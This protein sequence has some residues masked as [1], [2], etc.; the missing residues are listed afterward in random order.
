MSRKDA[1]ENVWQKVNENGQNPASATPTD[2]VENEF[3]QMIDLADQPESVSDINPVETEEEPAAVVADSAEEKDSS[4]SAESASEGDFYKPTLQRALARHKTAWAAWKAQILKFPLFFANL[5]YEIGYYAEYGLVCSARAL[6]KAAGFVGTKLKL[7]LKFTVRMLV[8]ALKV[9]L[10]LFWIPASH[11]ISAFHNVHDIWYSRDPEQPRETWKETGCYLWGGLRRHVHLIFDLLG[12]VLPVAAG[13]LFVFTVRTVMDYQYVLQ[14]SYDDQVLGYVASEEVF[15][16]AQ[17]DVKSRIVYTE[18]DAEQQWDLKPSYTLAVN[19]GIKLLNEDEVADAI[20]ASSGEEIIEATGLYM[21]GV[22]YGAVTEADRLRAELED[23]KAPYVTGEPDETVSFVNEPELVDG[24]YLRSSVV[25]YDNISELIH[26]QVAGEVRYTV[27]KGDSP[28]A[29]AHSYGL[30]TA[31][32][33]AMN[34]AMEDGNRLFVGDSLLV[35]QAV[36]FLQVQVTYRR[37]EQEEVAYQSVR[38]TTADLSFG[39][40]KVKTKGVNGVNECEYDYVYVDGILTSKTLV[41]TTV[42]SEP[43]NEEVL[44]G[45]A[46][47]PGV[48]MVPSSG[49]FMWPVPGYKYVSRGFTGLYAHNGM[50]ICGAYGTPIYAA[51]SGVVT[52]AKY[53]GS[54]YGVYVAIDHGNG[55]STLYGHCS[56]LAVSVGATVNQGDLIA[57]MGSTGNS[58]GNHCHFEIRV[59]GTQT[60]P[61]PYVGYG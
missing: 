26:G 4:V 2:K 45:T 42:L 7:A 16:T 22:F 5:F 50:D 51:Q 40:T 10:G 32:L 37:V 57:Y 13:A 48:T 33:Y 23:I 8:L 15:E 17:Q 38:T 27:Q 11:V 59:N 56:S 52:I 44:V 3:T 43:V 30:T 39:M 41:S 60:N 28:S 14:L 31:E 18:D 55:Y 29:I 35:S 58:T 53:T 61:A 6:K 20:L 47:R 34:P 36:S 12:W 49:G 9:V 19:D 25:D 24:V 54:G 46:V 1:D 21:N